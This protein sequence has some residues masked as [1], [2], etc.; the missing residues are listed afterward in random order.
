MSSEIFES[1]GINGALLISQIVNF[2]LLIVLL[3]KFAY[4]PV[5]KMLS[6]RS[7]KI[8][9]SLADAKR[10]EE[11]L[12]NTEETKIAEIKKAKEEAAE[13][14]KK[15]FETAQM[16]SEKTLDETR[17]KTQE[18]VAKAKEEIKD[19]KEKSVKEAE[20][21][22]ADLAISIAEK[23]IKKNLDAATEK[24]LAEETLSKIR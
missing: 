8:E 23:I 17:R 9:K 20:R 12:R 4:T 13:I 7:D 18:I 16:N 24:K 15:A 19:E 2:V 3:K 5:L 6:D 11:E 1:L 21:E 10:I 22:I 14:I